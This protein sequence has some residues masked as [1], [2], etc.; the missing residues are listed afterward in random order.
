MRLRL[1]AAAGVLLVVAGL[2]V[3]V[4][5]DAGLVRERTSVDGIPVSVLRPAGDGPFPGVVVV[6]GFSGSSRLM[7]GIGI[8]FARAGWLAALPDL[9]GHGA[10]P[11]SL[12][13]AD[14]PGEVMDVLDLLD[15]R[16]DVDQ[17]AMLGH[18]MGA[19]AVTEAAARRPELPVVALSLP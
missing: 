16:A 9:S 5:A 13:E 7:D 14:L 18:S 17:V 4:R 3:I 2:L 19:G 6:H 8:A 15:E 1:V 11:E 10:N 12:G